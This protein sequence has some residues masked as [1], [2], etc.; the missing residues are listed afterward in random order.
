MPETTGVAKLNELI[1]GTGTAVLTTVRPDGTLHSCPMAS[2]TADEM[3]ILWFIAH[4]HSEKVEAVR[5]NQQVN[6]AYVD[7]AGQRYVSVSGFCELMRDH[8]LTKQLWQPNYKDWFPGG[9]DDPELVL[10]KIDIRQAEYWE[11]SQ[12]RMVPLSGFPS[13]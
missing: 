10:L 9:P 12:G 8:S 2:H 7:D 11:A 6:V 13:R 3:G 5:T 1:Q 4:N